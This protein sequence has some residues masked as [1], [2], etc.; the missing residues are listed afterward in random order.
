VLSIV[1]AVWVA[2]ARPPAPARRPA[3]GE[4]SSTSA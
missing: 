4:S 3:L 1:V 2:S